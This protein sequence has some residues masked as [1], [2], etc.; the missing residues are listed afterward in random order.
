MNIF[1]LIPIYNPHM[2]TYIK[3]FFSGKMN[4]IS[5][6]FVILLVT[7]AYIKFSGIWEHNTPPA[8][9]VWWRGGGL[10]T[11]DVQI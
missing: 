7:S 11:C 4:K 3:I 10:I 6:Y 1:V 5:P 9:E 2:H 8:T